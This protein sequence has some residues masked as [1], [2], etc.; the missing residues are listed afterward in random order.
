MASDVLLDVDREYREKAT[1]GKLRLIAPRRFN[2]THQTWL[3]IRH[4]ERGDWHFSVLFSNTGL[5]HSLGRTKDWVIVYFH[6]DS[7][8]EGQR[9]V[10]TETRGKLC[11]ERVVRGS[12][13]ECE[14]HYRA[15]V[16]FPLVV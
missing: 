5:A 9:T 10:V 13:L 6:K 2:P 11:G 7:Q 4:T 8:A 12:E 14:E 3:P 1:A 15:P 16:Q